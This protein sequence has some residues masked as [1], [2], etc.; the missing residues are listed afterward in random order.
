MRGWRAWVV[1]PVIAC[2]IAVGG[3]ISSIVA[4]VALFQILALLLWLLVLAGYAV[5]RALTRRPLLAILVAIPV[6]CVALVASVQV[7]FGVPLYVRKR[8][9]PAIHAIEAYNAKFGG[10]PYGYVHDEGFDPDVRRAID[11]VGLMCTYSSRA[12]R[13]H[14][15]CMGVLFTKCTYAFE[16]KHWESWD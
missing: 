14:L 1:P 15:T 16:S 5:H 9:E 2:A 13:T 8:A 6:S 11:D 4:H 10:Y 3:Q 12:D 7:V